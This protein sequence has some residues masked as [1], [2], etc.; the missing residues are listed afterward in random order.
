MSTPIALVVVTNRKT[1]GYIP[2]RTKLQKVSGQVKIIDL[3]NVNNPLYYGEN[4]A[5]KLK[6]VFKNC[7]A[8]LVIC[9]PD[10]K[11]FLDSSGV[12]SDNKLIKDTE[13][14]VILDGFRN[15]PDKVILVAL[16]EEAKFHVPESLLGNEKPLSDVATIDAKI[17][18]RR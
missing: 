14:S 4:Y 17:K 15:F 3:D 13:K 10:L 7:Q 8:I 1:K 11:N 9:T 5:D 6:N 16:S 2:F 18:A 12:Q